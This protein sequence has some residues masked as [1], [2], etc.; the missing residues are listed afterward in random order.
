[1]SVQFTFVLNIYHNLSLN[2]L[3]AAL[4]THGLVLRSG[5]MAQ[6]RTRRRLPYRLTRHC[7]PTVTVSARC[8]SCAG[9]EDDG[10]QVFARRAIS[11]ARR[12]P[13]ISLNS[14]LAERRAWDERLGG[15]WQQ[16]VAIMMDLQPDSEV[17]TSDA[18]SAESGGSRS[19]FVFARIQTHYQ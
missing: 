9:V 3:R 5:R 19:V 13:S 8:R 17:D 2:H 11:V 10:V 16:T 14:K 1:M 18:L 6:S 4:W 12:T 7:L 15:E